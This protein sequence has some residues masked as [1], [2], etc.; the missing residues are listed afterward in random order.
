MHASVSRVLS[1]PCL[2]DLERQRFA[3]W[4]DYCTVT[5]VCRR[6]RAGMW[7]VWLLNRDAAANDSGPSRCGWG[8][9][10]IA[11]V[12]DCRVDAG[13]A[14]YMLRVGL[15]PSLISIPEFPHSGSKMA[16]WYPA[17]HSRQCTAL[18]TA[19]T[20]TR[21]ST[22]IQRAAA[23]PLQQLRDHAATGWRR[24]WE[25]WPACC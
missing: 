6:Q 12:L 15:H 5:Q 16:T 21:S 19:S 14:R 1:D 13:Y 20:H 17:V 10:Q 3:G 11:R 2:L 4:G 25:G 23:P 18:P 8:Y 7:C 24:E 9:F 22:S